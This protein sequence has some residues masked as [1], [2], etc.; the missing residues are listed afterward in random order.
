VSFART[1]CRALPADCQPAAV[2]YY[3]AALHPPEYSRIVWA[4]ARFQ[5][6]LSRSTQVPS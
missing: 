3:S 5:D 4:E 1:L 6:H 2:A